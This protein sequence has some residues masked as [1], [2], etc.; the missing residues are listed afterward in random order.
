L[1]PMCANRVPV[2]IAVAALIIVCVLLV[3][4][5]VS[6]IPVVRSLVVQEEFAYTYPIAET[7]EVQHT[8]T[9]MSS[10]LVHL[11]PY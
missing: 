2:K 7:R 4:M 6:W 11:K 5:F 3:A 8:E 9:I 1:R 10:G